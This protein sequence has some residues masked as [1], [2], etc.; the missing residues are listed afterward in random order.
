M[1]QSL[2]L[3]KLQERFPDKLIDQGSK[4]SEDFAVIQKESLLSVCRFLRD[5]QDLQYNVLTD[6]TAVDYLPMKKEPRFEVVYHL[7]SLPKKHRIR[8]KV[9]VGEEDCAV[10]SLV[11]LWKAAN[12][13]EREVWDMFGVQFKGHPDLRRILMYPEFKGHPLR[14]DYPLTQRQPLVE[15]RRPESYIPLDR[16][17]RK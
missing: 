7:H 12:W 5:D 16:V 13:L 1:E 14:K 6:V 2:T 17:A 11:P 8:L 4:W 15:L 10:D 3:K 9:P